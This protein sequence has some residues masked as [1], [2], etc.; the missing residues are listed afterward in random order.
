MS[1]PAEERVK[2]LTITPTGATL[3]A[4]VTNVRLDNLDDETWYAIEAAFH[5]YAVLV[6]PS[7]FLDGAAQQGG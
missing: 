3:G 5:K 4:L 7:Q 1:E 6:F 2:P